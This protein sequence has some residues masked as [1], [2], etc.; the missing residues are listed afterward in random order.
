MSIGFYGGYRT[1]KWVCSKCRKS[2]KTE[3]SSCPTCG[4][5]E[6]LKFIG[7]ILRA[8]KKNASR[9][10]WKKFWKLYKEMRYKVY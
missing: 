4:T 9:N 5:D 10:K 2:F 6:Y 3:H 8:P 1:Y 7:D